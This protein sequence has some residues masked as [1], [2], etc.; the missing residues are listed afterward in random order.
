MRDMELTGPAVGTG[1]MSLAGPVRQ[2]IGLGEVDLPPH[3]ELLG[4]IT[5]RLLSNFMEKAESRMNE[6][7]ITKL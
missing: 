5:V 7:A 4:D 6:N 3:W 2:Q 1:R